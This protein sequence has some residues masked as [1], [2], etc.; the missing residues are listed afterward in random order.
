MPYAIAR[1][2]R[3]NNHFSLNAFV[4]SDLTTG[5]KAS[6]IKITNSPKCT[7][8]SRCRRSIHPMVGTSSPGR[9]NKKHRI[10][11]QMIAGKKRIGG[12]LCF[13]TYHLLGRNHFIV[14]SSIHQATDIGY[15]T[16]FHFHDPARTIRIRINQCRIIL[17]CRI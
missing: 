9:K 7:T 5:Q 6:T 2:A 11:N 14:S 12:I 4:F 17:K 16:Y 1:M 3:A 10:R 8:L 15:I 13:T